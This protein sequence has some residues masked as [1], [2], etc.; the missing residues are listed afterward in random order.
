MNVYGMDIRGKLWVQR[1]SKIS[2]FPWSSADI[3]R[4]VFDDNSGNIYFGA[5]TSWKKPQATLDL[6][7]T[8]Q[9]VVFASTPLS[10]GWNIKT[11]VSDR[12]IMLTSNPNHIGTMGGSW[13]ISGM[14]SSGSHIHYAPYGLGYSTVNGERTLSD[15]VDSVPDIEHLHSINAGGTHSHSFDG[16]WRPA[17]VSYAVGV[18]QG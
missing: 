9:E 16:S 6:F 11:G 7:N 10:T 12:A 4:I 17:Y 13:I 8:G 2:Y 18:F 3:G 5:Q 1:I 14:T 15:I